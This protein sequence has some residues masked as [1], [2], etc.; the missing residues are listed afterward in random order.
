MAGKTLQVHKDRIKRILSYPLGKQ[1][2]E[3]YAEF[4]TIFA[5]D[6]MSSGEERAENMATL[7][8]HNDRRKWS[9]PARLPDIH[10]VDEKTNENLRIKRSSAAEKD[11]KNSPRH[12]SHST[13]VPP[14][15]SINKHE[16]A[17][18]YPLAS[19]YFQKW[20]TKNK[21]T[22]SC[23]DIINEEGHKENSEDA[24]T[25][26]LD[27]LNRFPSSPE[28]NTVLRSIFDKEKVVEE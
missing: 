17:I 4:D 1:D 25:A 10:F 13:N 5:I 24:K 27:L 14:L 22:T 20:Q 8:I 26:P 12:K 2:G 9:E 19:K 16:V 18:K 7:A 28:F 11:R 15:P 23:I 6:D 21:N 3:A